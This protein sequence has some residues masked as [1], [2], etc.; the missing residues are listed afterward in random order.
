MERIYP[1]RVWSGSHYMMS[2]AATARPRTAR[3]NSERLAPE[4][5]VVVGGRVED[6]GG[7][8]DSGSLVVLSLVGV[9]VLVLGFAVVMVAL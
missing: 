9:L 1:R 6:A 8:E 3:A 4:V 7:L 5:G 2:P